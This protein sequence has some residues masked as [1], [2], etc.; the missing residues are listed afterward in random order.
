LA[1]PSCYEEI[2]ISKLA[3][4]LK[5]IEEEYEQKVEELLTIEEKQEEILASS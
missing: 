4:E 5:K 2:G 3:D 1:D